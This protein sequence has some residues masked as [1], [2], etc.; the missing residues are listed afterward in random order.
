MYKQG[1]AYDRPF[2]E[3]DLLRLGREALRY[4]EEVTKP[5]D[6]RLR[7][8]ST[9]ALPAREQSLYSPAPLSDTLQVVKL[10]V[11][12]RNMSRLLGDQNELV[13][14]VLAGKSPAEA[15]KA[16]VAGTAVKTVEFRKKMAA[17][18]ALARSTEDP[19]MRVVRLLDGPSRKFRADFEQNDEPILR[20]AASKI[21]QARF[22]V[23]GANEYPDATFTFRVS[24]GDVRGYKN[25]SGAFI[26]WTTDFA[27]LYGRATG[28]EP[29]A[30]PDRWLKA[31]GRLNLKTPFNF[32]TTNDTHGGNSGSPT[33]NVRGELVGI[34][35]DGNLEGLPNRYVF[36]DES[37]RSVHVASQ[38]IIEALRSVYGAKSLVKELGL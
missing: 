21:A 19:V 1:Q 7:E 38:G 10:T 3:S 24:Y 36:T 13:L 34:L 29:F 5:D 4:A 20:A 26:P 35:F 28:L 12:L 16:M 18:T 11:A 9:P 6:Q 23:Y 32:V 2:T 8:F 31:K 15:A 14:Q 37:A 17:D 30:L 25:E 27:G 33:V 22:A